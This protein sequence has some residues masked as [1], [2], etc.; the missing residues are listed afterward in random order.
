MTAMCLG[1]YIWIAKTV[2]E[3]DKE[4]AVFES[5]NATNRAQAFV[6]KEQLDES[7]NFSDILITNFDPNTKSFSKIGEDLFKRKSELLALGVFESDHFLIFQAKDSQYQEE[8]FKSLLI[9]NQAPAFPFN[10]KGIVILTVPVKATSTTPERRLFLL[11]N[12][13]RTME[14]LTF[15][16]RTGGSF[17][18][19]EGQPLS[20]KAEFPFAFAQS[21]SKLLP[22]LKNMTEQTS[23]DKVSGRQYLIAV[24]DLQFG[25]LRVFNIIPKETAFLGLSL[26]YRKS[27]Q[28]F[29]FIIF[30]VLFVAVL[31]TS[32]L[33]RNLDKLTA[34]TAEVSK[35]HFDFEV[36]IQAKDEIGTLASSFKKMSQEIKR[37]IFETKEKARMESEL[38]TA[39][40][41]QENLFPPATFRGRGLEIEGLYRSA[42]E[43][44]GD[45][46]YHFEHTS[47][48]YIFICDATGHGAP[49]ALIT[50]AAKAAVNLMKKEVEL[51][52][53]KLV[54][55]FNYVL[56]E[57]AKGTIL[58]TGFILHIKPDRSIEYVNASHE[59]PMIYNNGE[60]DF[61][62]D[63][64]NPRFGQAL[65]SKYS[66][67]TL[68][69]LNNPYIL[70]YTD[71]ITSQ[72][73]DKGREFGDKKLNRILQ[74]MK[75]SE[76][77]LG[78]VNQTILESVDSYRQDVDQADDYTIVSVR[79]SSV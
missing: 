26:L 73:N 70:L 60:L 11:L 20:A 52:I 43:C 3:T 44:G 57:T 10:Q 41:I 31:M 18:A 34:A 4:V 2:F 48:T 74:G 35:G 51:N 27:V 75:L 6:L 8:V 1:V 9:K 7:L 53:T 66:S 49:A 22:L 64:I 29:A 68:R 77:S 16:Q 32:T 30:V 61:L 14:I 62:I 78:I 55:T 47:G 59:P 58:M 36:G 38:K 63:P 15:N 5:A 71:G 17:L 37:L 21:F 50:A 72:A 69:G 40:T 12:M 45:W 54:D 46:W 79:L 67:R 76:D 33:L 28:F 25:S 19:V 13:E 42:S 39:Q 56:H 65:D 23:I 24:K